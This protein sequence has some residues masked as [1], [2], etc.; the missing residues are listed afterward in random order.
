[1]HKHGYDCRVAIF[2][3][4]ALLVPEKTRQISL[5]SH[6]AIAIRRVL[7]S[8]K[9]RCS[10]SLES[11]KRGSKTSEKM[12]MQNLPRPPEAAAISGGSSSEIQP[13]LPPVGAV[14]DAP[15]GPGFSRAIP[16]PGGPAAAGYW[17]RIKVR[18]QQQM[19]EMRERALEQQGQE[20]RS[21]AENLSA[22][23]IAAQEV[24]AP[25]PASWSERARRSWALVKLLDSGPLAKWVARALVCAFYVNQVAEAVEMW[26]HLKNAP[27]RRRWADEPPPRPPAFPVFMVAV[28][29]PCALLCAGGLLVPLT[30]GA[31]LAT[32]L[33]EDARLSW[34]QIVSIVR[35]GSRPTE[36]LAKRL[37]MIGVALLV[38]AHSARDRAK[39]RTYAG[40]L[41]TD[42]Q[43]SRTP[44]RKKSAALL[45]GR[46]LLACLLLFAGL[47]QVRRVMARG[48]ALWQAAALTPRQQAAAAAAL[49]AAYGPRMQPDM[50]TPSGGKGSVA[51]AAMTAA[52]AAV[53]AAGAAAAG[54]A[55]AGAP[56]PGI[57]AA[58]AT[59]GAAAA[60][61]GGAAAAIGSGPGAAPDLAA[62]TATGAARH[63]FGVPD[64]HDNNWQLLQMVLCVPLALGWQTGLTCRGLVAV[65]LL[66]A[67]T[68]W[69]FWAWYWPSWHYAAHVRLHFFT[70]LAVAGGLVLL[71][72]LGA[73]HFT[74]D[75]LLGRKTD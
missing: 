43:G 20:W 33:Y 50:A 54:A 12:Q 3:V 49:Q 19:I 9:L 10:I 37:A 65:L 5:P 39:M 7:G 17:A 11:G 53:T 29:L 52:E 42:D 2:H 34:R 72:C 66:E 56:L 21:A 69:P 4:Q 70:N 48:G 57:A 30:G 46:L 1:M 75:S 6:L 8:C 71:Q 32:T 68:C 40:M 59:A 55:A 16:G 22:V 24:V 51:E 73:G 15:A 58:G 44:G 38:V 26:V 36:L 27:H 63:H 74:M 67:V 62:A 23:K 60:V 35:Y 61:G 45:A 41:L 31:L 13:L 18:A 25:E 64:S 47:S 14:A 28:L